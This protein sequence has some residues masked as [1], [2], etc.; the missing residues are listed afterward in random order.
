[1][2]SLTKL[3]DT[4]MADQFDIDDLESVRSEPELDDERAHLVT[5]AKVYAIAEKYVWF[6]VTPCF[7]SPLD[8]APLLA[9]LLS[10]AYADCLMHLPLLLHVLRCVARR[11]TADKPR[12]LRH[13]RAFGPI[14]RLATHPTCQITARNPA[15]FS[16]STFCGIQSAAL[17]GI[18]SLHV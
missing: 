4:P 8:Y 10:F 9:L 16:P 18:L 7:T 3:P 17:L 6:L 5:H 15:S 12:D 14:T 1:V 11:K 2:D 13:G